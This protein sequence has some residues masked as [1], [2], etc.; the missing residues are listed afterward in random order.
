LFALIVLA[1][2]VDT[3]KRDKR[4]SQEEEAVI[5]ELRD[6]AVE[7]PVRNEVGERK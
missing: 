7:M 3:W 1:V 6:T 2:G 4:R 5:A